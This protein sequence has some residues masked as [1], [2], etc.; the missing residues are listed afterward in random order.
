MRRRIGRNAMSL[1]QVLNELVA[2]WGKVS[3]VLFLYE[4]VGIVSF[5]LGCTEKTSLI[6]RAKGH[7][8]CRANTVPKLSLR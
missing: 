6:G 3:H 2:G 8:R 1:R 5:S 4:V 7:L